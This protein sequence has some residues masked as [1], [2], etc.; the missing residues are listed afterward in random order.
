MKVN[1]TRAQRL[2]L[3]VLFCHP[4]LKFDGL[5]EMKIFIRARAALGIV[6]PTGHLTSKRS[7]RIPQEGL[8]TPY[9]FVLDGP[10][11]TFI[12]DKVVPLACR[13]NATVMVLAQFFSDVEGGGSE[14]PAS[15]LNIIEDWSPVEGPVT[16]TLDD[17]RGFLSLPE[18]APVDVLAACEALCT[19]VGDATS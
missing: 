4:D 8:R 13:N 17:L 19:P 16:R 5:N 3:A 12:L 11:G 6:E 14:E 10:V 18:A 9:A 7:F 1:L 2:E 15:P